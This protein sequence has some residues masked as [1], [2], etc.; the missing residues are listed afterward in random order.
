MP[1]ELRPVDKIEIIALM[2]NVSDPFTKSHNGMRYNEFQYR[3]GIN[4]KKDMCGADFCRAC[5]GLS[6]LIK[7]HVDGNIHTL[8]FDTGPDDHLVVDNAKRMQVD[9]TEVEAIVLSHGH[10]DHYGGVLSV[11][12]AIDKKD[13]PVYTHPELFLPRAFQKNELIKVSYT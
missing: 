1:Y 5:N 13:L 7:L 2:D 9:L 12:D 3:F 10:F 4:Q 8:L 11:L 6:L